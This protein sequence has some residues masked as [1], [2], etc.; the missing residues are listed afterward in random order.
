MDV[1]FGL[2]FLFFQKEKINAIAL[3]VIVENLNYV[4]L[5]IFVLFQEKE[6][7]FILIRYMILV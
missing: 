2:Y 4:N 1:I 3:I 7:L 5:T 6:I